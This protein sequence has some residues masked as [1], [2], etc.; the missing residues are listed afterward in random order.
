LWYVVVVPSMSVTAIVLSLFG[1]VA[2][3]TPPWTH[4][5][6]VALIIWPVLPLAGILALTRF[7]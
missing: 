3:T 2:R 1:L 6:A 4:S 5:L 7:A